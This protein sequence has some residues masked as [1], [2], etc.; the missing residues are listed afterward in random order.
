[1]D[2]WV[3]YQVGLEFVQIDIQSTIESQRSSDGRNNLS[4]QSVQ[5]GVGW[6]FNVE[7]SSADVVDSLVVNHE[8]TVRVLEGGMGSEDGV[9][10]FNNSR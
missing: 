9:V 7:V 1:M 10:G 5:V 8:G 4:N 6:S 2:S 3:W